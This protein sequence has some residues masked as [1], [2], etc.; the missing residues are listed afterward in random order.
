MAESKY[1]RGRRSER[2]RSKGRY[3]PTKLL[4]TGAAGCRAIVEVC[5][6][7]V[8]EL[9]ALQRRHVVLCRGK[10]AYVPLAAQPA[11]STRDR[12]HSFETRA[13]SL[14]LSPPLVQGHLPTHALV[15]I[16]LISG[17]ARPRTDL[18]CA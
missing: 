6:I 7:T 10:R 1:C 15:S 14:N 11:L 3:I 12:V 9:F 17:L 5:Q 8:L 18:A 13:K 4:H 2:G 16:L